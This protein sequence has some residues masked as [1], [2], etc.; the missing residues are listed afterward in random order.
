MIQAT[1][2]RYA[3]GPTW[4]RFGHHSP[5]LLTAYEAARSTRFEHGQSG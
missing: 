3:A 5:H 2:T 4:P 1:E